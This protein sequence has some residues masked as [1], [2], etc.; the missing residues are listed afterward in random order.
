MDLEELVLKSRFI[1]EYGRIKP[2]LD[3]LICQQNNGVIDT[4]VNMGDL[5]NSIVELLAKAIVGEESEK[6]MLLEKFKVEK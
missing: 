6:D 5:K 4:D 2:K 3:T 1:N